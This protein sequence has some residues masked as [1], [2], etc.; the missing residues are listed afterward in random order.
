ME[1]LIK[2]AQNGDQDAFTELV[3]L[4]QNDLYKIAKTRVSNEDDL[5]DAIQE[6]MI[7]T[8]KS[9]KKLKDP[10][11]FKKWIT[12][13]LINKCNRIYRRKYKTDISY[14]EANIEEFLKASSSQD[15]ESDLEYY[16][17]LKDLKYEEK[18]ILILYYKEKYKVKEIKNILNMKVS[19]INTHLFRA[20]AKLKEKLKEGG[21]LNV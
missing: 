20:R 9:I 16:E 11:S 19:T 2:R 14:E 4:I 7:E 21:E 10:S 13:I 8:Y 17:L 5:E 1:E 3:K 18:I 15:I 12:T 6:T